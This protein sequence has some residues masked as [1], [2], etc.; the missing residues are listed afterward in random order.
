MT[1]SHTI[2]DFDFETAPPQVALDG[3]FDFLE[4]DFTLPPAT[5]RSRLREPAYIARIEWSVAGHD[6]LKGL[7]RLAKV[8]RMVIGDLVHA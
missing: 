3:D 2:A 4:F 8:A 1:R 7:Q 6:G 5:I